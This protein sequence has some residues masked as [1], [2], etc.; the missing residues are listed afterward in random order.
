MFITRLLS[1]FF[2]STFLL[3]TPSYAEE[4]TDEQ[5]KATNKINFIKKRIEN[6]QITIEQ[7]QAALKTKLVEYK[8]AEDDA[9]KNQIQ[10][11]IMQI[12]AKIN[13]LNQSFVTLSTGGIQFSDV[14]PKESKKLDWQSD[15]MEIGK[16]LF[17]ALKNLTE[18]PRQIDN[19]NRLIE[20]Y[21]EQIALNT[22]ALAYIKTLEKAELD[23]KTT[24]LLTK[25]KAT[26]L[27]QKQDDERLKNVAHFQL[28]ELL[29][30][31]E[32]VLELTNKKLKEFVTGKGLTLLIAVVI[33]T[34]IV[35][36]G[37][38]FQKHLDKRAQNTYLNFSQRL[39]RIL[40]KTATMIIA[41][42]ALLLVFYLR[43]DWLFMGLAFIILLSVAFSLKSTLP[44]Y[45]NEIKMLLDISTV[46][47]GERVIYNGIPWKVEK[48]NVQSILVNPDLRGG[49]IRMSLKQLANLHSRKFNS[50]EPW[51]PCKEGDFV[52]LEAGLGQYG[53]VVLASP[54]SVQLRAYGGSIITYPTAD[55]LQLNPRNISCQSFS[56]YTEFGI[57][58]SLQDIATSEVIETFKKEISEQIKATHYGDFF[59]RIDIEFNLANASSL[60]YKII[61]HFDGQAAKYYRSITRNLQ[62][63]CVNVCNTHNWS[64]PYQQLVVHTQGS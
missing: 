6:I 24:S 61:A 36:I 35:L 45:I 27:Q 38:I 63:Y 2:L 5:I 60:D 37:S 41:V 51:F 31:K 23:S 49:T 50:N 46:R 12:R 57:D 32:S 8:K 62:K 11:E 64:I 54:E 42:V 30:D 28:E 3:I 16:P 39:K 44:Q 21:D 19:L 55:F 18:K 15:L 47:E 25:V 48:L 43:N 56:V 9:Y 33:F 13:E 53:Q 14:L 52:V 17:S 40:Y 20:S 4:S 10:K 58:Y 59:T 29:N 1:Y 34:A 7:T 22:Q 26:R